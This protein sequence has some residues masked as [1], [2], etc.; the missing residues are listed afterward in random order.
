VVEVIVL[1]ARHGDLFAD[2]RGGV[3]AE[4]LDQ[5]VVD[6]DRLVAAPQLPERDALDD[7]RPSDQ[8]AQGRGAVVAEALDQL[9]VDADR[10]VAAPQLPERGALVEQRLG[11]LFAQGR[12]GVVAEALDQ[13]VVD[14]DLLVAA[15]QLRRASRASRSPA[16][17]PG[18]GSPLP[19]RPGSPVTRR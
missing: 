12:G 15:P 16:T 2:R 1:S 14:A 10:L 4:A 11:D 5:L 19:R 6:A 7:Q 13:L 3:V 18:A 8:L 17:R 9:V